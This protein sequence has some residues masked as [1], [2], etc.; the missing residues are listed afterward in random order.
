MANSTYNNNYTIY[1]ERNANANANQ[2]AFNADPETVALRKAYDECLDTCYPSP[3]YPEYAAGESENS[4]KQ[5]HA[6]WSEAQMKF[7]A[8][9]DECRT[10]H[11]FSAL[12]KRLMAVQGGKRRKT[13][14]RNKKNRSTRR[15]RNKRC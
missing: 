6:A 12:E 9:F 4:K 10:K 14:R 2:A 13:A 7:V 3:P 11:P 5:K 15:N 8:C 1:D